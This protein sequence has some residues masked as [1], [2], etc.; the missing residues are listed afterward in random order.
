MTRQT[1]T[2]EYPRLTDIREV[3]ANDGTRHINPCG[4]SGDKI[5]YLRG[6]Y[7]VCFGGDTAQARA[8]E[9]DIILQQPIF[10]FDM[11]MVKMIRGLSADGWEQQMLVLQ[12][13]IMCGKRLAR[14]EAAQ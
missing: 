2:V 12:Y 3:W 6:G 11:D 1:K 10:C 5:M 8:V 7:N 13:G 14:G 4:Q 9:M